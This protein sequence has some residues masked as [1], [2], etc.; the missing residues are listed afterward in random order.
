MGEKFMGEGVSRFKTE[1]GQKDCAGRSPQ[2]T[3]HLQ[4]L[5]PSP[6]LSRLYEEGPLIEDGD[7]KEK[8][9]PMMDDHHGALPFAISSL[10]A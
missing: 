8:Q 6:E 4:R 7:R 5:M 2:K 1:W 3:K 10:N 9:R